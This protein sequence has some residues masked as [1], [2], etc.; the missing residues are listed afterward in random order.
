MRLLILGATGRLGGA[1]L[2]EAL[3]RGWE[4]A[5]LVRDP[6]RL[7]VAHPRLTVIQ[8]DVCVSE[9]VEAAMAGCDAVVSALGTRRGQ[10]PPAMLVTAATNLVAAAHATGVRRLAIVASAG[11]L[12]A[13]AH[14]L[15]RDAPGYP[16]AFKA[17]SAAHLAAY[18]VVAAS[19]LDWTVYCPP[20]LVEGDREALLTV[21]RDYLPPGPKRVS[22]P[23]LARLMLDER[24]S[25][26]HRHWRV[27][28]IGA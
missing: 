17:G 24:E 21:R 4:V 12:Q 20:E 10:E 18:E 8:G 23:A 16:A 5:A 1:V 2:A 26:A 27:G 19:D 6:A 7:A 25:G 13:D 3:A 28:V 11:I 15:R 22:M 14:S 9:D